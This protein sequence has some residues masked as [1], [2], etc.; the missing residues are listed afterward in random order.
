MDIAISFIEKSPRLNTL[1]CVQL[2]FSLCSGPLTEAL[3]PLREKFYLIIGNLGSEGVSLRDQIFKQI[4]E[5]IEM[6]GS[7]LQ[8][9]PKMAE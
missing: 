8:S 5:I 3:Y 2:L 6:M 4:P 7:D 9:T 1:S